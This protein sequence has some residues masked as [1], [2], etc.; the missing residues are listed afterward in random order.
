MREERKYRLF[1]VDQGSNST[2]IRRPAAAGVDLNV[3][4]FEAVIAPSVPSA[5]RLARYISTVFRLCFLILA[6][7]SQ[8]GYF[9]LFQLLFLSVKKL[10]DNK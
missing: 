3:I 10:C 1:E 9:I 2:V 5:G 4:G 7:L 6:C 8:A